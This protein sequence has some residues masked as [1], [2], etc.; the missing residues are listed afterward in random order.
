MNRGRVFQPEWR[1]TVFT[2]VMAPLM[3]GL[4]FWQLARADEKA[5]LAADFAAKQVRPPVSGLA[6]DGLSSAD[7]A[8]LPV[9]LEG[10]LDAA[11]YFLLDNRLRGGVFGNEVVEVLSAAHDDRLFLV[12]RGWV[13]A[14]PARLSLPEVERVEGVVRLNGYLYVAPD[15]PYLLGEQQLE[16]GWPKRV[17]ALEV[18][19]I[20][21]ALGVSADE[22][23]PYPLRLD[24]DSTGA[25]LTDWQVLNQ[26]PAKHTGY[27]VQWFT[28]ATVLALFWLARSFRQ[29]DA[30]DAGDI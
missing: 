9:T 4:G 29:R 30:T 27:A 19:V 26:S 24:A 16:S 7:L 25:L 8:Y 21:D 3:V 18:D 5:A 6:L 13:P 17:Q 15:K 28:M 23:Y 10:Q 20:A 1:I 2:L 14:D 12:N 11:R 22:L